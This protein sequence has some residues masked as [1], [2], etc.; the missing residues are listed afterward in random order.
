MKDHGIGLSLE[1]QKSLFVRPYSRSRFDRRL[2]GLGLGLFLCNQ[3]I[4]AHMGEIGVESSPDDGSTFW[5]TL[6]LAPA[7]TTTNA[8]VSTSDA[9]G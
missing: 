1:Q 2:T 7:A 5:L 6:P 8:S 9:V 3:I 4:Q